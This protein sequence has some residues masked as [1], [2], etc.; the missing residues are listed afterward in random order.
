MPRKEQPSPGPRSA[1]SPSSSATGVASGPAPD[2]GEAVFP[3][4]GIGKD[5]YTHD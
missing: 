1:E 5:L 2:D 4:V 3:I